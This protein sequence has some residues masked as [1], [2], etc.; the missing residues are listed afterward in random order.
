MMSMGAIFLYSPLWVL[1]RFP[2]IAGCTMMVRRKTHRDMTKRGT[3]HRKYLFKSPPEVKIPFLPPSRV[4][5]S[6]RPPQ[7]PRHFTTNTPLSPYT[8][9]PSAEPPVHLPTSPTTPKSLSIHLPS[10]ILDADEPQIPPPD[11][12]LPP[13]LRLPPRSPNRKPTDPFEMHHP[14]I[15]AQTAAR[16]RAQHERAKRSQ[17]HDS[18]APPPQTSRPSARAPKPTN[19]Q[20]ADR[21]REQKF[22]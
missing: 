20:A 3:T 5:D 2:A 18:S 11:V 12:N 16:S 22:F 4:N 10:L 21:R 6:T 17:S 1:I 14:P 8:P 9:L 7:Q 13:P 15:S 19:Q